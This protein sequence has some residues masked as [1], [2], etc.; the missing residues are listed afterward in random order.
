L[1]NKVADAQRAAILYKENIALGQ[2]EL[3][4]LGKSSR[5]D[6]VDIPEIDSMT[7]DVWGCQK[8]ES[9]I[10]IFVSLETFPSNSSLDGCFIP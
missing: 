3:G 5:R 6:I 7:F 4:R 9:A 8:N 2:G 10:S 1:A